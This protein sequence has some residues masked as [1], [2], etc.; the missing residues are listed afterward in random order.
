M[1]LNKHEGFTYSNLR[2]M[3]I[4]NKLLMLNPELKV[5]D[6]IQVIN[7]ALVVF[8]LICDAHT[9]ADLER[10]AIVE[11]MLDTANDFNFYVKDLI[12]QSTNT[13]EVLNEYIDKYIDI[14]TNE[15]KK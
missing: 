15:V 4:R 11:D 3:D 13:N 14:K 1:M 9:N 2:I 6:D 7:L 10:H 5:P 8:S 12:E